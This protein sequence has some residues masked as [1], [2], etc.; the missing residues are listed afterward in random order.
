MFNREH[1]KHMC[2]SDIHEL[3][4][5]VPRIFLHSAVPKIK[6]NKHCKY[7]D[8]KAK[9]NITPDNVCNQISPD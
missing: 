8:T 7:N 9:T 5:A 2:T 3:W 1:F 6:E 4:G